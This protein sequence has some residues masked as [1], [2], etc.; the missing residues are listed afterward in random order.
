[1][2]LCFQSSPNRFGLAGGKSI[3]PRSLCGLV[4]PWSGKSPVQL[5]R[6]YLITTIGQRSECIILGSDN[7]VIQRGSIGTM[8]GRMLSGFVF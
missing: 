5:R 2:V 7:M 6:G 1:M 3:H 8:V 4:V